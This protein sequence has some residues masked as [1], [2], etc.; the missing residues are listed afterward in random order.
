MNN[1]KKLA[2]LFLI[3]ISSRL[4]FAQDYTKDV[5]S[6]ETIMSALTEV[7]SGPADEDRDWDRFSY[8]FSKDAKLIPTQKTETGEVSYNY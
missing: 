7:I 8:L 4:S 2:L 3:L 1:F 5:Q 6:I